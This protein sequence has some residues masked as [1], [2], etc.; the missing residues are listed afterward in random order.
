MIVQNT[1]SVTLFVES[2]L[3]GV[4]AGLCGHMTGDQKFKISK[5]Y[6]LK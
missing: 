1:N 6:R 5:E 4:I 2:E 3:Q